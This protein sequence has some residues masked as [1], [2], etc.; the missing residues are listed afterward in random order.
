[1]HS[2]ETGTIALDI[3][4]LFTVIRLLGVACLLRLGGLPSA[5][6]N[7]GLLSSELG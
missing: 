6:L 4:L 1:M 5:S 3:G 2:E 7:V